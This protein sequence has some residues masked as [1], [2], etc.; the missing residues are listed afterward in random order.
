ME[1]AQ[2][3][4]CRSGP[5]LCACK[6]NRTAPKPL[7]CHG[8]DCHEA[9]HADN[10]LQRRSGLCYLPSAALAEAVAREGLTLVAEGHTNF[11]R[12]APF[13][14]LHLRCGTQDAPH[15]ALPACVAPHEMAPHETASG[16]ARL[17]WAPRR[18]PQFSTDTGS[19]PQVV[20]GGRR[21]APRRRPHPGLVPGPN[22]GG[23]HGS[24]ICALSAAASQRQRRRA[25]QR[26]GL[27]QRAGGG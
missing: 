19:L 4:P 10:S 12:R 26:A 18:V 11:T 5:G 13:Q 15:S 8:P 20:R 7:L 17:P 21:G 1:I 14:Q 9:N 27:V 6:H 16:A 22:P 3:C 23:P 24:R 2:A 25:Q